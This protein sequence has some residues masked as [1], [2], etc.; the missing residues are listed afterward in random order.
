MLQ[1]AGVTHLA[2]EASSHGLDQYRLDGSR[3]QVAG[4][5][6]FSRDH[7]DYHGSMQAYLQAKLRLFTDLL[8]P[9]G[10]A[11]INADMAEAAQISSAI[12]ANLR[13]IRYGIKGQEIRLLKK[14]NLPDGQLLT[15]DIFGE[16][17]T[18]CLPLIGGFQAENALCALGCVIASEGLG[19]VPRIIEALENLQG[20]PGRLE[21][22]GASPTGGAVYVDYAHTPGGLETVLKAIRPH[23][24]N[25]LWTIFG[26]G[27]DRDKGKR[28]QMAA[29]TADLSDVVI[30]SDDNPRSEDPAAIRQDACAGFTDAHR[31]RTHI[32][33]IGDREAAIKAAING[34]KAGD[35]L[36]I[37]GKG[38][39]QGQIIGTQTLPFD[40]RDVARKLLEAYHNDTNK[41]DTGSATLGGT[42][43]GGGGHGQN[44]GSMGRANG[45]NR[46]I[47]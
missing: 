25:K 8:S 10:H 30:V 33:E 24:Q 2:L 21:Y 45:H 7:L 9:D 3:I 16:Q 26:C 37:A 12:P 13:Q 46:H 15:V 1:K 41:P 20:A 19:L 28:P 17:K 36:V 27:G 22:V 29:V 23:C 31:Q 40:D 6:S 39:E 4:F 43:H 18:L 34:L 14:D 42:G 5:T 44:T 32:E 38:H 35:V 47:N 11:V